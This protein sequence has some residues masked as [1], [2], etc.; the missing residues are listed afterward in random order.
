MSCQSEEKEDVALSPPGFTTPTKADS[1]DGACHGEPDAEGTEAKSDANVEQN[2][3]SLRACSVAL[4]KDVF[5]IWLQ[6]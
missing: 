2:S 3:T 4:M 6:W 5:Y 1:N